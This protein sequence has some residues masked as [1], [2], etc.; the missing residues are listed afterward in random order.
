MNIIRDQV[1]ATCLSSQ[2]RRQ[3]LSTQ[4]LTL[5]RVREMSKTF[6]TSSM[7]STKLGQV[8]LKDE[9]ANALESKH[10]APKKKTQHC[11]NGGTTFKG[12]CF[13]CGFVGHKGYECRR[14]KGKQCQSCGKVGHFASVCR[15]KN[16]ENN[17]RRDTDKWK[18]SKKTRDKVNRLTTELSEQQ[19]E[20]EFFYVVKNDENTNVGVEDKE[21]KVNFEDDVY[22]FSFANAVDL[23]NYNVEVNG[24]VIPVLIDS[25]STLNLINEHTYSRLKDPKRLNKSNVRIFAYQSKAPLP[26]KGKFRAKVKYKSSYMDTRFYVISG[27]GMAFLI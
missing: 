10:N 22:M 9:F 8:E 16:K 13:K 24:V 14:T 6:E 4:G 1:I 23:P 26:Q 2:L 15:N 25:G 27:Q 21:T 3:L 11:S 18:S 7:L 5:T 17:D 12:T 20:A 19:K